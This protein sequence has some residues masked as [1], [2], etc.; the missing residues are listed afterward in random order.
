MND[1]EFRQQV[2]ENLQQAFEQ[3]AK[4]DSGAVESQD[5]LRFLQEAI[6]MLKKL[7]A[8]KAEEEAQKESADEESKEAAADAQPASDDAEKP[9]EDAAEQQW[10]QN[11]VELY[12]AIQSLNSDY[13]GFN[14][15][16]FMRSVQTLAAFSAQGNDL[17]K[18]LQDSH[19]RFEQADGASGV[20]DVRSRTVD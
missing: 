18:L 15:D 6:A 13:D 16:D 2:K 4:N 3:R 19:A 20:V 10:D 7:S 17:E 5:A 9:A 12:N 1:E 8:R 14:L 11:K